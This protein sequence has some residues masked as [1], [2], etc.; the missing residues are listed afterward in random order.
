MLGA[1][2]FGTLCVVYTI[3]MSK[4]DIIN[5]VYSLIESRLSPKLTYHGIHHTKDVHDVCKFYIGHYKISDSEAELLEIAAVAH[6]IGFIH[7]YR[8]HE[9]VGAEMIKEVMFDHNYSEDQM[10]AV[11][12]MILATKVPQQPKNFLSEILC[13]ADLDYLGRSDFD[14]IGRTL[15][16]EWELY[17]VFEDLDENFD[18]LQISFLKNHSF[19]TDYARKYRTPEKLKHLAALEAR[20]GQEA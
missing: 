3:G 1:D 20:L 4:K 13:D 12:E 15:K 8:N 10:D 14:I 6:D 19:H 18:K 7:T 5:D 9:A 11:A 16:N 2:K 17:G